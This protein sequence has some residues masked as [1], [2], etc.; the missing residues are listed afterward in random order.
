MALNTT[1]F[2]LQ[3]SGV[4]ALAM[5]DRRHGSWFTSWSGHQLPRDMR[6]QLTGS[7]VLKR[8]YAP[9]LRINSDVRSS[10]VSRVASMAPAS[11]RFNVR[12]TAASTVPRRSRSI[13]RPP[14]VS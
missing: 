10:S 13:A 3:P 9:S 6:A 11:R 2:D 12:R 4:R 5:P 1:C 7:F 14:D 8:I